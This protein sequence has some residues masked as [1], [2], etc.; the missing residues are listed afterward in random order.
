MN[1]YPEGKSPPIEGVGGSELPNRVEEYSL[2][3]FGALII[4]A[5]TA[6]HAAVE[7]PWTQWVDSTRL[8]VNT[9]AQTLLN[10]RSALVA[11]GL[12]A[13]K[14]PALSEITPAHD[15][16]PHGGSVLR[17]PT[18]EVHKADPEAQSALLEATDL[19]YAAEEEIP[20]PETRLTEKGRA[21]LVAHL[22][23]FSSE[24]SDTDVSNRAYN[25][26]VLALGTHNFTTTK[27]EQLSARGR[28]GSHKDQPKVPVSLF[29]LHVANVRPSAPGMLNPRAVAA[30]LAVDGELRAAGLLSPRGQR[31]QRFEAQ[32]YLAD[33]PPAE[34]LPRHVKWTKPKSYWEQLCADVAAGTPDIVALRLVLDA[35]HPAYSQY[36]MGRKQFPS[37]MEI[38]GLGLVHA[39][40]QHMKLYEQAERALLRY[41]TVRAGTG[42]NYTTLGIARV[43]A[44]ANLRRAAGDVIPEIPVGRLITLTRD[45][46]LISS[47]T[48]T[49]AG[50]RN[51]TSE[52]TDVITFCKDRLTLEAQRE[53]TERHEQRMS[54][55]RFILNGGGPTR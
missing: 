47:F 31:R 34:R 1:K 44:E 2:D 3:G 7:N 15:F 52:V 55:V 51:L 23:Q 29:G 21:A 32:V 40:H 41:G 50:G 30:A 9:A 12:A 24:L 35:L 5:K 22:Q 45:R 39:Y 11:Q 38:P 46:R 4:G 18:F 25:E 19:A 6:L 8:R 49:M 16:A 27:Q 10:Q 43:T 54:A 26:L 48:R 28:L 20:L 53:R 37:T 33:M 14:L 42:G 17:I 13:L 36:A